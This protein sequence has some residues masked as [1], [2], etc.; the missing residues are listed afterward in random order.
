MASHTKK[1]RSDFI[2]GIL[3][4]EGSFSTVYLAKEI[5][6]NRECAVKVLEKSHILKEKKEKYVTR[7]KDILLKINHPFFIKLYFTF[8]DEGNLYFG[9]SYA[10]NGQL[11]D[12]I[13]KLGKFDLEISRYYSAEIVLALEYLH[14]IN[15]IHRDLKPENILMN[16][17]MH[18]QITDFGSARILS[19][20]DL[21]D[22]DESTTSEKNLSVEEETAHAPAT[23]ERSFTRRHSF[24][25]TAQYVS[26]EVLNS[27][28][29]CFSSDLWALGCMVYQFLTG[30]HPFTGRHEYE[31]FQR[32]LRLEYKMPDDLDDCS[33]D[34]IEKILVL[35]RK[36]RLGCKEMGGYNS[37]K[38][39]PFF[40]DIKWEELVTCTPP[41][42]PGNQGSSFENGTKD[43]EEDEFAKEITYRNNIPYKFIDVI[44]VGIFL[45]QSDY[46][47][48]C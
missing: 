39:H 26:P 29:S 6:T 31:I 3:I 12:Y 4:G 27:N 46:T 40:A 41:L 16:E 47:V 33:K 30:L 36:K 42:Q 34:F 22:I 20:E 48:K 45:S 15:I 23:V 11:L 28:F 32:I 9:L 18:I 17:G 2:F 37:L 13:K 38:S 43:C 8:Q 44:I 5:N 7:E 25:G 19:E 10:S 21:K 35:D 24:V 1:K 14:S